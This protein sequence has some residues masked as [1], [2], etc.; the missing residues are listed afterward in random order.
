[1]GAAL[2]NVANGLDWAFLDIVP[3]AHNLTGRL[4]PA[5]AE[6]SSM[7]AESSVLW[8]AVWVSFEL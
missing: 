6:W 2:R 7:E 3:K 4:L 1:M 5:C 8:D